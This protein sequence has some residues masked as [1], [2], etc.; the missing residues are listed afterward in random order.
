[1]SSFDHHTKKEK[2]TEYL[3][4]IAPFLANCLMTMYKTISSFNL[5]TNFFFF[6]LVSIS[7]QE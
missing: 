5:P 6:V 2:K 3:S 4:Q 7:I 1:M